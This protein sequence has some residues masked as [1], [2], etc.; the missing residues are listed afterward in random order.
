VNERVAGSLFDAA[1]VLTFSMVPFTWIA[2]TSTN[3][4]MF[5]LAREDAVG[6]DVAQGLVVRW[7]YLHAFRSLFPLF[8]ATCGFRGL[9][10][11]I[12]I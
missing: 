5:T 4:A 2:M 3:D 7:A 9:L 1:A 12:R 10:A 8:G 6:W 11:G